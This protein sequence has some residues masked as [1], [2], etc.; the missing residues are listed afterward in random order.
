MKQAAKRLA[1]SLVDSPAVS[2]LV[3]LLEGVDQQ[4]PNLLRVV[5]YHRVDHPESRPSLYPRVTVTPEAFAAQ[6]QFLATHYHP[7]SLPELLDTPNNKPLTLPP[8][9][10]LVTFDDAYCD[11]AEQAW[12][13]MQRH[14][15][16]ATLFV[17]TAFPDHP[18]RIF[19]WDRLYQALRTTPRRDVLSTPVG[20]LPLE[21][22]G[23]R[24]QALLTLRDYI[25]TQPH[26]A[27]MPWVEEVCAELDA[28]PPE[29]AVLGWDALRRLAAEGVTL[30]AHTRTHPLLNRISLE[31][32][33]AEALGSLQ[34]LQANI[35]PVPPIFA[36]P[37]GGIN[38]EVVQGLAQEGFQLAFTTGRGLNDW[39]TADRLR[40]RR[41]NAGPRTSL[42][43]LRLQ[44]LPQSRY[45]KQRIP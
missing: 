34:D 17:P 5:T 41:I 19:W 11:F 27:A 1:R 29:A 38:D 2:G 24:E 14:H 3:S 35:G 33:R 30:G 22:A 7:L 15:I 8:R 25:K 9:A 31:E 10:V 18:E 26:A 45:L 42:T 39:R 12:P 16:P 36:Y 43:A 21:T 37:S 40:L 20:D 28:L 13:V 4:Q 32:A 23:Q 44:L 6:M